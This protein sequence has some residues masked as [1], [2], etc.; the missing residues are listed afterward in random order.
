MERFYRLA[1]NLFFMRMTYFKFLFVSLLFLSCSTED[2][3]QTQA[4]I[5]IGTWGMYLSEYEGEGA[6]NEEKDPDLEENQIKFN[7]D[8]TI[9]KIHGQPINGTWKNMDNGTYKFVIAQEEEIIK[10]EFPSEEKM[11]IIH[12][13]FEADYYQRLE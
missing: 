2:E 10:L 3:P 12:Q 13:E 4:D 6:G 1:Q 8:G 7:S 5:I 11:V 9:G